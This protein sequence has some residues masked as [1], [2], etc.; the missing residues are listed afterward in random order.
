MSLVISC[1]VAFDDIDDMMGMESGGG[2][3]LDETEGLFFVSSVSNT[4]CEVVEGLSLEDH[5][6]F[7]LS[8]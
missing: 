3:G 5:D 2:G 4:C 8:L 1:E 6:V 7:L